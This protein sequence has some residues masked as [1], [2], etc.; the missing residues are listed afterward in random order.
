MPSVPSAGNALGAKLEKHAPGA[1][2]RKIC[3]R[4]QARKHEPGACQAQKNAERVTQVSY[5][6]LQLCFS[7][8]WLEKTACTILTVENW[9]VKRKPL[10]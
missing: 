3:V 1:E 2:R 4:Y 9:P 10:N 8:N 5:D 6:W 7:G